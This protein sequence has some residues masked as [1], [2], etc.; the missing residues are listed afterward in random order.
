MWGSTPLF[1]PSHNWGLY[2][3]EVYFWKDISSYFL[4]W[5]EVHK[6][7]SELSQV[8]FGNKSQAQDHYHAISIILKII[9]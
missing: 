1:D 3:C 5:F 9:K 4:K 7:F 6:L 2:M 8:K